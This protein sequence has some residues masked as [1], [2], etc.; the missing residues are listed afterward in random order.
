MRRRSWLDIP[1]LKKDVRVGPKLEESRPDRIPGGTTEVVGGV[2]KYVSSVGPIPTS[3]I[4]ECNFLISG[5]SI[6]VQRRRLERWGT[7]KKNRQQLVHSRLQR[8]PTTTSPRARSAPSGTTV[9]RNTEP[10]KEKGKGESS[11]SGA[12]TD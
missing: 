11:T 7:S 8:N 9:V 5:R 6:Y 2:R 10:E 1:I 4:N 12:T 3:D